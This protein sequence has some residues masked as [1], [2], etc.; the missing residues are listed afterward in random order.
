[1]GDVDEVDLKEG[2]IAIVKYSCPLSSFYSLRAMHSLYDVR[3]KSISYAATS[4]VRYC[5]AATKCLVLSW[6]MPLPHVTR[7]PGLTCYAGTE[8][9]VLCH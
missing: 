9:P 4:C 6:A 7:C 2:E 3:Y 1:M 5:Y 8:C